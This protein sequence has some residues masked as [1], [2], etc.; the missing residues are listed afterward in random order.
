MPKARQ[1]RRDVAPTQARAAD[2]N[3]A[4]NLGAPNAANNGGAAKKADRQTEVFQ[5]TKLCKF[6]LLGVCLRGAD[7]KYAHDV[8]ELQSPPDLFRTKLCKSLVQT[9]T[10]T[11][12]D[13][14]YA[15]SKDDLRPM[16]MAE[17]KR[18]DT[19]SA[20]TAS[21][22]MARERSSS[23]GSA[24]SAERQAGGSSNPN[25]PLKVP[26]GRLGGSSA[27]P[28]S[29]P[30]GIQEKMTSLTA[31][32]QALNAQALFDLDWQRIMIKQQRAEAAIFQAGQAA[33]MAE[34]MEAMQN[35]GWYDHVRANQM[36]PYP[37][38]VGGG[39]QPG[40]DGEAFT[41]PAAV[42]KQSRS[43]GPNWPFDNS[44]LD[45]ANLAVSLAEE[46]LRADAAANGAMGSNAPGL[47]V[48][49]KKR[50]GQSKK[51]PFGDEP[52]RVPYPLRGP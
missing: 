1:Q 44:G 21:Q 13:C 49:G 37:D 52:A 23:D 2:T 20:M 8:Q 32:Q 50:N 51:V 30:P 34:A 17:Q 9:G 25:E 7:C 5:R 45:L 36:Q 29:M 18:A 31:G 48:D 26:L 22:V 42:P 16:P 41:A 28:D 12:A 15:H 40:F 47:P 46:A 10:C 3:S 43:N 6:H 27:L 38:V 11:D 24:R 14:R 19:N 35:M 33:A 4:P 39:W